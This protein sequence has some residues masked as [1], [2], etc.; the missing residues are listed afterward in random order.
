MSRIDARQ[1]KAS[2]DL[3]DVV[4]REL[5]EPAGTFRDHIK[6]SSPFRSGDSTPS[7]AVYQDH[8][9]DFGGGDKSDKAT[10]GD[11]FDFMLL[12]RGMEFK[13]TLHHLTG[14]TLA[15]L[16]RIDPAKKPTLEK[17]KRKLI[18]EPISDLAHFEKRLDLV[19]PYLKRRAINP[20]VARAFHLGAD[21]FTRYYKTLDDRRLR[22]TSNRVVIPSIF[23]D[24]Y[25]SLTY[26][27]DDFSCNE[28]LLSDDDVC[29]NDIIAVRDM[30]E[31]TGTSFKDI[32]GKHMDQTFGLR[33]WK[34]MAE[35]PF[36]MQQLIQ[37]NGK[38]GWKFV[39]LPY[40]LID[41]G[42][43]NALANISAGFP[44]IAMKTI[45]NVDL[46]KMLRRVSIILVIQHNDD[47]GKR[48]VDAVMNK[49]GNP[50]NARYI[51]LPNE[52]NDT[53]EMAEA[54]RLRSFLTKPPIGLDINH[55]W[56]MW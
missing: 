5:G 49:L 51:K 7:F 3:R 48:Y 25:L 42:A 1:V 11:V 37:P 20:D 4:R 2:V 43:M 21:Q 34:P 26:R 14:G 8:Y 41:E 33:Y 17:P 27:R 56:R 30:A 35:R 18:R 47:A 45:S 32:Y 10:F 12:H 54:G 16:P 28:W 22:F 15:D 53:G 39:N 9:Y 6:Y 46:K 23:G 19:I 50:D 52:F 55:L 31:R 38:G 36:G 24:N 40:I 29:M 44:T 13:D